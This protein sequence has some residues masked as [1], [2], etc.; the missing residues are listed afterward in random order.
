MSRPAPEDVAAARRGADGRGRGWCRRTVGGLVATAGL[1]LGAVP[2]TGPALA[3]SHV[4]PAAATGNAVPTDPGPATSVPAASAVPAAQASAAVAPGDTMPLAIT[5]D[6]V[7][8][9]TVGPAST[10][11]LAGTV[12]NTTGAD[13]VDLVLRLQRGPVL[14]TRDA[15]RRNDEAPSAS[16]N[17]F[18]PFINLVD[19]LPAGQSAPFR[20]QTSAAEL[21]LSQLGVYPLLVNVNG[22]PAGQPEQRVGQVDT[23]LP[24]FP[25]QVPAATQITWLWP[26]VDRPH[27]DASGAFLD[28]DLAAEVAGGGRLE[29]LLSIAEA[30]PQAPLLLAVDP[31]LLQN[32]RV[33]VGGYQLPDGSTGTGGPAAAA[34]LARLTRL[35][36][37]HRVLALPYADADVVALVRAGLQAQAADAIALG[38]RLVTGVLG[39]A[40]ADTLSWPIDG[41]LTEA[42]AQVFADNGTQQV[43]LSAAA[44][45][46]GA[47]GARTVGARTTLPVP[48]GMTALVSD[49]ELDG[50]VAAADSWPTGPRLAEQ[51]YLA[52]LAM[53]TAEAPSISRHLLVAPPR[54]WDARA[55][56]AE[57]MLADPG[58]ETWLAPVDVSAD[59]ALPGLA[60]RGELV[61]P[62]SAGAAELDPVGLRQLTDAVTVIADF[63][64]MLVLDTTEDRRAAAAILDPM[65]T[66]VLAAASSAWR[67]DPAVLRERGA[68]LRAQIDAQRRRVLLVVPADG[69]YSIA[70]TQAPLVFTVQNKLPVPVQVR[71]SVDSS[72][73]AGLST[74]DVGNQVLAPGSRTLIEVPA[75]VERS[76]EF[77]VTA[78]IFTPAGGTLG[79]PVRLTVRSTAYGVISIVITAGAGVLLFVLFAIRLIRRI[80]HGRRPD[81]PARQR[82]VEQT[83]LR[84][85]T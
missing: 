78:A 84:A 48:A 29:R 58:T 42:A 52:E 39:L 61:Y 46:A 63:R 22:I 71:M 11:V 6:D 47:A 16:A 31:L 75:T 60:D 74:G 44:F 5:V 76:G 20:Y 49:P 1:L 18:A 38:R 12:R 85:G 83:P 69:T 10:I 57:P 82:P 30:D 35:A 54:R 59:P 37:T 25:G 15:L 55:V 72:L 23:Y 36:A 73:V 17:G 62:E 3:T 80:R 79:E 9:R 7:A 24:F 56:Y 2:L 21:G 27:R 41:V 4:D 33:M 53:I 43:V 70:S 32:L 26:L 77:R 40:V 68:A 34:W 65:G 51:R 50:I 67:S 13:M 81:P 19:R 64:S 66:A 28:D 45:T 14:T 8:P